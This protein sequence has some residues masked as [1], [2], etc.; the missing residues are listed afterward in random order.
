[1]LHIPLTF[2]AG[3]RKFHHLE[4]YGGKQIHLTEIIQDTGPLLVA[5]WNAVSWLIHLQTQ[6]FSQPTDPT[7]V[8]ITFLS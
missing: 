8:L 5:R 6:A 4:M 3:H 7:T 2:L 1:M